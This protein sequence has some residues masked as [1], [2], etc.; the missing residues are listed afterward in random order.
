[1]AG[2]S[3]NSERSVGFARAVE[4][5]EVDAVRDH[6]QLRAPHRALGEQDMRRGVRVRDGAGVQDAGGPVE[7]CARLRLESLVAHRGDDGGHPCRPSGEPADDA[8]LVEE[9]DHDVRALLAQRGDRVAQRRRTGTRRQQL[10]RPAGRCAEVVVGQQQVDAHLEPRGAE[11]CS[12]SQELGLGAAT[13]QAV[14]EHRDTDRTPVGRPRRCHAVPL[15]RFRR[16]GGS[17]GQ[18]SIGKAR[19]DHDAGAHGAADGA[20]TGP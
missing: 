13:L 19:G 3:P 4:R 10:H 14:D 6:L 11:G 9:V 12:H 16:P 2:S 7:Q 5:A 1:M 20:R 15:G 18:Q 8:G 17:A